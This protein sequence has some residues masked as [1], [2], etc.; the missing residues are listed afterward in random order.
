MKLSSK[1]LRRIIAEEAAK[2]TRDTPEDAAKDTEEVDA[3]EY[4]D[5]LEKKVDMMKALKIEEARL[6]RRVKKI[7]EEKK[8]LALN[9]AD[10]E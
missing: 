5:T 1:V 8:V 10:S 3:D 7:R 9:I 2:Y 6:L 4:A